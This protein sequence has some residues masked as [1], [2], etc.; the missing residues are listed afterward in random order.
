MHSVRRRPVL[1][2]AC[3]KTC[4]TSRSQLT[5]MGSIATVRRGRF[6][7]TRIH[8][9]LPNCRHSFPSGGIMT[10]QRARTCGIRSM[11]MLVLAI[12]VA[13]VARTPLAQAAMSVRY[14]A[15]GV[16][17]G[18]HGGGGRLVS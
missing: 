14:V 2:I 3:T 1:H 11:L 8:G 9:P 17:D 12:A 10:E 13:V 6:E 18:P 15:G 16:P 4:V 7:V 5:R